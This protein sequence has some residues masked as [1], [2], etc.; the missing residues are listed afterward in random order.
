[1]SEPMERPRPRPMTG[2]QERNIG[3]LLRDLSREAPTDE[4]RAYFS[5]LR[6]QF[7]SGELVYSGVRSSDWT[8]E[9]ASK[10]IR[11]FTAKLHQIRGSHEAVPLRPGDGPLEA[12]SVL[13]LPPLGVFRVFKE[14]S[15]WVWT[16]NTGTHAKEAKGKPSDSQEVAQYNLKVHQLRY[17]IAEKLCKRGHWRWG[18]NRKRVGGGCRACD[19][20]STAR[21]AAVKRGNPEPDMQK[22]SDEYYIK[23]GGRLR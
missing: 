1:M 19:N 9:V 2:P 11:I 16:C 18:E 20:A 7:N 3:G 15:A 6:S 5:R 21:L 14:D 10:L 17:H 8:S 12:S 22:L 4:E 23:Y 13:P